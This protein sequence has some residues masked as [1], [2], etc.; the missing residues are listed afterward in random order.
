M[1][2]LFWR[3]L[4]Y[5][6]LICMYFF[7]AA[8]LH[9]HSATTWD[10]DQG[11]NLWSDSNNWS[12]GVPTNADDVTF[13]DVTNQI[14]D[15][16]GAT[17]DFEDITISASDAYTF[18][19]GTLRADDNEF[20]IG[21]SVNGSGAV[22]F[23]NNFDLSLVNSYKLQ[24]NGSN[25]TAPIINGD[26][27]FNNSNDTVTS[28]EFAGSHDYTINGNWNFESTNGSN[29]HINLIAAT[30]QRDIDMN[31]NLS[32]HS[33]IAE[34][35]YAVV[36]A[37]NHGN[38][39]TLDNVLRLDGTISNGTSGGLSLGFIGGDIYAGNRNHGA[40]LIT[41][42]NTFSGTGGTTDDGWNPGFIVEA[43][44]V[45]VGHNNALGLGTVYM[46]RH[47]PTQVTNNRPTILTNGAYTVSNNIDLEIME[48]NF[49]KNSHTGAFTVGG[50]TADTS[51]YS[52]NISFAG[53]NNGKAF[54][55]LHLQSV[56]GGQVNFTGGINGSNANIGV[57]EKTGAGTV[58]LSGN[59]THDYRFVIRNG[60]LLASGN[61]PVSGTGIFGNA[62]AG[63]VWLG[64]TRTNYG[65][66]R[67]VSNEDLTGTYS[68][69]GGTGGTGSFTGMPT[70][71][72]GVALSN[73]DKVLIRDQDIAFENG[74]YSVTNAASGTWE[75]DTSFDANSEVIHG[76][77]VTATSGTYYS[78]ERFYL[79]PHSTFQLN[80]DPF[81]TDEDGILAFTLDE[82]SH[83]PSLL[84]TGAYTIARDIV[85]KDNAFITAST[86]GGNSSD[87]SIYSGSISLERDLVVTAA[88]GGTVTFS[89][90]FSGSN[91][92]SKT[93]AGE[94][95]FSGSSTGLSGTVT[96]STGT[97]DLT[98][99]LGGNL[100]VS[101]GATLE[102]NGNGSTT[103]RI[104][105][106]LNLNSGAILSPGS[107]S[108]S[109]QMIIAGNSTISNGGTYVWS[110]SNAD[111]NSSF[112]PTG[113]LG[114]DWDSITFTGSLDLSSLT[115]A[116]KLNI[117]ITS[118]GTTGWDFGV[119][120]GSG[121]GF[122][123]LEASSISW[124]GG[125]FNE[126]FFNL[127]ATGFT[128]GDTWWMN[129]SIY[130]SGNALY[131][132]YDAV[133]EP[134]TWLLISILPF[135]I[136]AKFLIARFQARARDDKESQG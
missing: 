1:V 105:G 134:G 71:V 81:V 22:T 98:G 83:T 75:R 36:M 8:G 55:A 68:S 65:T 38:I 135:L 76:A 103:G 7:S 60:T 116:N 127:D 10:G 5:I 63:A 104:D 70:S 72:N 19:N 102:G 46:N 101:S 18:Q 128:D 37:P 30:Q 97:L 109:G 99:R 111:L 84:T 133:P 48:N 79:Q 124:N 49:Y 13:P 51:I 44:T 52:G 50:N 26:V 64:D 132:R 113:S 100:V 74:I 47:S 32:G 15:L 34:H 42:N 129:W 86:I 93:G 122:K 92:I 80:D 106:V 40:V 29:N 27:T 119:P 126:D 91:N 66:V 58:E 62:S 69:S 85:V 115:V 77:Y 61:A 2:E 107:A 67:V 33:S 57:V 130:E 35:Q 78:G 82:S 125:A 110:I 89:G 28:L 56:S 87:S 11:N 3:K 117:N 118:S 120:T 114:S 73:G 17:R 25:S 43:G 4:R 20:H 112:D 90:A 96:V 24:F 23:N 136:A 39:S 31:G 94:T 9:L 95:I 88:S 16:G 6:I 54:G 131:L 41:G 53:I 123:I 108:G 59:S 45:L 14:I 12:A 121:T 21:I